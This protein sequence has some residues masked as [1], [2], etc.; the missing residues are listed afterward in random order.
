[1]EGQG[2]LQ[3]GHG[4][5]RLAFRVWESVEAEWGPWDKAGMCLAQ[6][7]RAWDSVT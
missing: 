3:R 1:M 4:E 6:A 2:G 5:G 7:G